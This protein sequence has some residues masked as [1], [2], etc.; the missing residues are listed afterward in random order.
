MTAPIQIVDCHQHFWRLGQGN[1]PWLEQPDPGPHRYG[2]VSPLQK[3]YLPADYRR[4]TAG[5][6]IAATV[7]VEAEWNPT[8]PIAET[9]WLHGLAETE[10]RP[11]A[12]V[13]QAWFAR[14]DIAAVLSGQAEFPL[15]RGIR[16]K[17]AAAPGPGQVRSGLPGSMSDP[18]WRRGYALLAEYG[19]H[20]ELQTRYWHL[21]EAAVLARDY[22]HTAIILNHA[23][24]PE[25]RSK[26]GL[27]AWREGMQ[28]LA[29]QP[30]VA[31]KISGIG[32]AGHAWSTE[33]NVE[34][35]R[36]VIRIFGVNRCMFASN[37]PVDRLVGAF[38]TIFN[39]FMAITADLS[40]GDRGKLFHDNAVTAY[41]L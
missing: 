29:K 12:I 14:D 38:A 18:N 3:N 5:F 39:G 36:E 19:L 26:T 2:P 34:V 37:Y 21:A 31:V 24:V 8:D 28:T 13:A 4:D 1:Y 25:D 9:R 22:P 20:Y 16:Q 6:E 11:N 41:R 35:V 15:V 17:P 33:R 40:D 27:A 7:H 32:E 23:G 10:G 30:N